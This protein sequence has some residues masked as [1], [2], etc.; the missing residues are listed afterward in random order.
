MNKRSLLV[1]SLCAAAL[2]PAVFLASEQG[3][4]GAG[5]CAASVEESRRHM[6]RG[7]DFF[8]HKRFAE[9][10]AEFD[11]AFAA[12]PY[13]AF[14]CNAAMAYGEGGD[15]ANAILRYEAF[16]KAEPNPP[17]LARI[18]KTLA[19]LA[20][21]QAAKQ[22]AAAAAAAAAVA[23]A[24][25]G[26]GDAGAPVADG[27]PTPLF[28]FSDAGAAASPSPDLGATVQSQVVIESDPPGAPL[29]IFLKKPGAAAFK[30]GGANTGWEKVTPAVKTPYDIS[31]PAGDYHLV[32]DAFQDYKASETELELRPGRVYAFKANLSQGT[33]LGFLRVTA[34]I[35]GA[36]IYLDDP[37][38]H[39]KHPWGSTPFGDLLDAGEHRVW[40]E[41][42]GFLPF[43]QKVTI[44]HG[45]VVELGAELER[46][47][48][49]YL[50]VD[51]NADEISVKVDGVS[52]GSYS[53]IGEPL[54]I[55]LPSG[56]HKVEL[57]ASGRKAFS[58]TV[59]VPRG[60]EIAVHGRLSYA[61]PR[62]DAALSGALA[63]GA[64]LGGLYL[65]QQPSNQFVKDFQSPIG[66]RSVQADNQ[67]WLKVGGG[68]AVGLSGLL[69][70][71]TVYTLVHDPNPP[72]QLKSD[73]PRE[74]EGSPVRKS[75]IAIQGVAPVVGQR[76]GGLL[77]QGSF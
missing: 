16:L 75:C 3:A 17:D 6:D 26:P 74:F 62:R 64:A 36:P 12:Q 15:F 59:E 53:A 50:R 33:F 42:P 66:L 51:G 8:D 18:K 38:P 46:E 11:A 61:P 60:Q 71:A 56:P 7:L 9:A 37:P 24:D 27:G 25:G 70:A 58:G 43:V 39:K 57:D 52:Y 72:S 73:E 65:L 23:N 47:K 21:Q 44:E 28:D 55:R 31:L 48:F 67:P 2:A 40:I 4:W 49:G 54:K 41:V 34:A 29:R 10:A 13:S 32:L 20:A 76:E 1:L 45:K 22:A 69:V 14:L 68:V 77:L 63:V 30:L 35:E 5:P 19:W